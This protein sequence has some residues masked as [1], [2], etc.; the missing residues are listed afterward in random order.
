MV[1]EVEDAEMIEGRAGFGDDLRRREA[2]VENAM[3][4]E[5]AKMIEGRGGFGDNLR[6]KEAWAENVEASEGAA[7]MEV[8]GEENV[9]ASPGAKD[10]EKEVGWEFEDAKK[11]QDDLEGEEAA[12]ENAPEK[13]HL[14]E[15]ENNDESMNAH[16]KKVE[17]SRVRNAAA[18]ENV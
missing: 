12:T 18:R 16:L 4:V 9:Q 6:R 15:V 14:R 3:E 17:D 8:P 1:M 11:I 2:C 10:V 13:E 5:D 7:R